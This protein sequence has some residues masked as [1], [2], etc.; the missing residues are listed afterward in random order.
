MFK[1]GALLIGLLAAGPLMAAEPVD[2]DMVTRIQQEAFQNSKVMETM[3]QLTEVIGPRL[4]GS[5]GM[6]RAHRW[7]G[8]QLREWGLSNVHDEAWDDFGRGWDFSYA[9]VEMLEPRTLPLRALPMSWT[10]GTDGPVEGEV[11][12]VTLEKPEDLEQYKGKLAGKILLLD[13]LRPYVRATEPATRRNDAASLASL[14]DFPIPVDSAERDQWKTEYM[15][16]RELAQ[17]SNA[18]FAEEGVLATPG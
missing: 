9:R 1:H 2:L 12:A 17:A 15:K 18:F 14:H 6:L 7:T 13:P 16:S 10:P 5:P 11:M 3:A 8:E 4:T